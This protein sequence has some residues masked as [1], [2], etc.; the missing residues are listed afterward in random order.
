[1]NWEIVSL[2]R[3]N[4]TARQLVT[5][6]HDLTHQAITNMWPIHYEAIKGIKRLI[7]SED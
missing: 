2:N 3:K 7:G 6:G 5:L 1:M 4:K